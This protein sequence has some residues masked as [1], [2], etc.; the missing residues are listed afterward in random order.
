MYWLLTKLLL[1]DYD[2]NPYQHF[3]ANCDKTKISEMALWVSGLGLVPG[4]HF[5][6]WD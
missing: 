3:D 2:I 5:V 1:E 6:V 4:C